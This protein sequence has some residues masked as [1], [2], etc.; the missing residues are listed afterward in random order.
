MSCVIASERIRLASNVRVNNGLQTHRL[1][2]DIRGWSKMGSFARESS[3][4]PSKRVF[5]S[6]DFGTR[7]PSDSRISIACS[8]ERRWLVSLTNPFKIERLTD[9][10]F[11]EQVFHH[12]EVELFP[13]RRLQVVDFH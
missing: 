11:V 2:M 12:Q 4:S 13:R 10:L 3:H 6:V 1:E 5:P 9:I 7:R 8:N